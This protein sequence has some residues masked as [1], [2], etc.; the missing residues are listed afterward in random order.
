[1]VIYSSKYKEKL[2][3]EL[4]VLNK[5]GRLSLTHERENGSTGLSIPIGRDGTYIGLI[6]VQNG[7][8]N[9]PRLTFVDK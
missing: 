6:K 4:D 5:S 2:E 3:N 1:M 8:V 7:I 9:H